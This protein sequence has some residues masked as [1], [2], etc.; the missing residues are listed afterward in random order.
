MN[1]YWPAGITS[2][3]GGVEKGEAKHMLAP[4]ATAKRKGTGLASICTALCN[5]MG[6]RS[7]AVAVLLINMVSSEVVK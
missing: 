2:A 4:T 7:T 1:V 5:A 6:A 3:L